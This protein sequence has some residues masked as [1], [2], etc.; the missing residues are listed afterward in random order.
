MAADK[1]SFTTAFQKAFT[2]AKR[3]QVCCNCCRAAVGRAVASLLERATPE[4]RDRLAQY[5][6]TWM[7][8]EDARLRRAACQVGLAG[9]L[10][11][12]ARRKHR[13]S[14]VEAWNKQVPSTRGF[15]AWR[16]GFA[17]AIA[18]RRSI[19]ELLLL[20]TLYVVCHRTWWLSRGGCL[21]AAQGSCSGNRRPLHEPVT[22]LTAAMLIPWQGYMAA[23]TGQPLRTALHSE[24]VD[25]WRWTTPQ[26][27]PGCQVVTSIST[28]Y[29]LSRI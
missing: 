10:C 9:S 7:A 11:C 28:N 1:A 2:K 19:Y 8:G 5:S 23:C 12:A 22:C 6:I 25:L 13:T 14:H 20:S 24:Q 17:H 3:C 27:S 4:R 15:F 21:H 16:E 29:L 18:L 26:A